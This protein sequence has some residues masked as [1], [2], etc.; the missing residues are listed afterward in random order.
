MPPCPCHPVLY[1]LI[2]RFS[3]IL[4]AAGQGQWESSTKGKVGQVLSGRPSVSPPNRESMHSLCPQLPCH[5]HSLTTKSQLF[6][7]KNTLRSANPFS[8]SPRIHNLA[9]RVDPVKV[10]RMRVFG[11][12]LQE[13]IHSLLN[14]SRKRIV[15]FQKHKCCSCL[16][17]SY[18][19]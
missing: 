19:F 9:V 15:T 10:E 5:L 3:S 18:F 4:P 8:L 1:P 7:K 13:Q 17:I 12:K 6:F 2:Q 11:A 14:S 16:I